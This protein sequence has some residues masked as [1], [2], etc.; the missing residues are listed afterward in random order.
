[1]P[2]PLDKTEQNTLKCVYYRGRKMLSELQDI[3]DQSSPTLSKIQLLP[4][5]INQLSHLIS[6]L[7]RE[8]SW[9]QPPTVRINVVWFYLCMLFY[10]LMKSLSTFL[11]LILQ[12]KFQPK[13]YSQQ[14]NVMSFKKVPRQEMS[15]NYLADFPISCWRSFF[16]RVHNLSKGYGIQPQ[17][18]ATK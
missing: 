12:D 6:H 14:N 5:R 10:D 4:Q 17:I 9:S 18:W 13:V 8:W 16:H 7:L 11:S 1:M 3:R 2:I 15:S